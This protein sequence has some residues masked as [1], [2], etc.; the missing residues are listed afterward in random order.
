[1]DNWTENAMEQEDNHQ[2]NKKD[3]EEKSEKVRG[4]I[5]FIVLILGKVVEATLTILALFKGV[6]KP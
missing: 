3:C 5:T 4:K 1:M 2:P 6:K